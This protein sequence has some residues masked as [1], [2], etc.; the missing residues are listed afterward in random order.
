MAYDA[1]SERVILFG[2]YED[3]NTIVNDVWAY[4]A[5]TNTWQEMSPDSTPCKG[6]CP[7]AYDVQSD[8]IIMFLGC[9]ADPKASNRFRSQ[10]G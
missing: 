3:E 4:D 10:R 2:G 9:V 6:N 5:G 8:R 7:V 1:E